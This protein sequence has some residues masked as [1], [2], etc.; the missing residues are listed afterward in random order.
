MRRAGRRPAPGRRCRDPVA[1]LVVELAP[2]M[3]PAGPPGDGPVEEVEDQS[4]RGEDGDRDEQRGRQGRR[5]QARARRRSPPGSR[6]ASGDRARR[7]QPPAV[8]E[9][10][11]PGERRGLGRVQVHRR[12][13]PRCGPRPGSLAAGSGGCPG[14]AAGIVLAPDRVPVGS[15]RLPRARRPLMV[16][17]RAETASRPQRRS[18]PT[19]RSRNEVS[20][21]SIPAMTRAMSSGS[22]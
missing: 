21:T 13:D 16:R 20:T 18:G 8:D 10:I 2:G 1:H 3:R 15:G 22:G 12:S 5:E 4:K 7:L 19:T 6:R 9:R 11:E 14:P 17:R